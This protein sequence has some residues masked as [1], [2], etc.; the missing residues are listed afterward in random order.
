MADYV[1]KV[2]YSFKCVIYFAA[3]DA[4][5]YNQ[6][7]VIPLASSGHIADQIYGLL[8]LILCVEKNHKIIIRKITKYDCSYLDNVNLGFN[9]RFNAHV[10][11]LY[12]IFTPDGCHP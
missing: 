10:Q 3:V 1:D 12:E 6:Y 7:Q 2:L 9:D 5:E 8:L 11:I 4:S